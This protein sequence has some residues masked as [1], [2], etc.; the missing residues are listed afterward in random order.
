LR[1]TEKEAEHLGG[2]SFG[3]KIGKKEGGKTQSRANE[4]G[5]N[6]RAQNT[7]DGEIKGV[8]KV[9]STRKGGEF[10]LP[11]NFSVGGVK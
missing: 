3:P 5:G 11:P 9:K 1:G 4:L 7:G 10:R 6:T 2:K 8:G